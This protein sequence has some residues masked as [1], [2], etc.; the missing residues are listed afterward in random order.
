MFKK[1]LIKNN[2]SFVEN[3]SIDNKEM[4]FIKYKYM[5]KILKYLKRYKINHTETYACHYEWLV[6]TLN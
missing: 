6:I 4:F 3:T 1:Y 2:I 5:N